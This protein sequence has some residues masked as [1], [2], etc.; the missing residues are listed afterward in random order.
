M[1]E[2][3]YTRIGKQSVEAKEAANLLARARERAKTQA[4]IL[5]KWS[6]LIQERSSDGMIPDHAPTYEQLL[7]THNEI[8]RAKNKLHELGADE[9][10]KM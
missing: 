7:N 6:N 3:D 10:G 9:N 8:T 1:T 5:A 4:T 2:E